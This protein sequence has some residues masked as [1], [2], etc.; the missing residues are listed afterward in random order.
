MADE[1]LD[2]AIVGAGWHGLAMAKT[3]SEAYPSARIALFDSA[4][5]VGGVWAKERLYPGLKT[6]N[7]LGSYEFGDFPMCPDRFKVRPGEHIPGAVV[8]EY[9][10]QFAEEYDLM[11]RLRLNTKVESAEVVEYGEW[12]LLVSNT[13]DE[14]SKMRGIK[15]KKLVVATGLTSKPSMPTF[16]G[17]SEFQ[18][19]LFHSI[20]LKDRAKDLESAREVVVLGA[21][22]SSWDTCYSAAISGAHVNMVIRPGGGGPSWVLPAF[23]TPLKLSIQRLATTRLCSLFEPCVWAAES[24]GFPWIRYLL[25]RTIVGRRLVSAL[26][27]VLDM[28]VLRANGYDDHPELKKLKPWTDT[29]W[30]GNNLGIHNYEQ[31]W[32]DLVRKGRINIHVADVASLSGDGV[33]LSSGA[34]INADT[35]VCCTGWETLPSIKFLP[36]EVIDGLGFPSTSLQTSET[37]MQDARTRILKTVPSL[38]PG[39]RKVLPACAAAPIRE[40]EAKNRGSTRSNYQL[41]RFMV[42][43]SQKLFQHRNIAVIGAHLAVNAITV[44]QAQALW[45]TAFF[46]DK[47]ANI[48]DS[49][50]SYR[51]IE[52]QTILHAEYCRLRHPAAGGGAGHRCPD[53]VFDGLL[54]TDLLLRDLGVEVRRKRS[55]WRELFCRYLPSDYQGLVEEWVAKRIN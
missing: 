42:P 50:V 24:S 34:V 36:E 33:H 52:Y 39:P 51:E 49:K 26:W 31:N 43:P 10:R 30:M 17:Q 14:P 35:F 1:E 41:Y 4:K 6:N 37:L 21:S 16:P 20:H 46:N 19:K 25:H 29:F 5:S 3:Y 32:F 53:L 27:G 13:A 44:A 12:I 28:I 15:A 55:W 8:N 54:Y 40:H 45:V 11:S 48:S 38:R 23:F 22:K 2:L 18:G 7:M 9:L 47:I